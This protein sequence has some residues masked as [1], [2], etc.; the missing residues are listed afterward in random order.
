MIASE[1]PDTDCKKSL[2]SGDEHG[3]PPEKKKRKFTQIESDEVLDR[4]IQSELDNSNDAAPNDQ[5]SPEVKNEQRRSATEKSANQE[6]VEKFDSCLGLITYLK[7]KVNSK[8][9][10]FI[11]VRRGHSLQQYLTIWHREANRNL[12]VKSIKSAFCR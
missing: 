6:T 10:F 5:L 7:E 2:Y 8:D 3:D 4:Q 11:V 1:N 12:P 9:Q